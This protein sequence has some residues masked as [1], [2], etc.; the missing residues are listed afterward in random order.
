MSKKIRGFFASKIMRCGADENIQ[1]GAVFNPLCELGD[2]SG[3]GEN[4][5]LN[6]PVTIGK[7]VIMG[8]ECVFFTKNH[9]FS[10]TDIPI[11]LQGYTETKPII[12]EDDVWIGQRVIVLPGVHIGEGSIIGAGSVVTKD[13]PPFVV[14]AGNPARIVKHR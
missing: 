13:I 11:R 1:K 3:I 6:G 12:I 2:Y 14:A 7:N 9:M 5:I 10:R 8:P 4:C